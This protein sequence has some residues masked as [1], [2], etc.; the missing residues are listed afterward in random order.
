M[1][2]FL[3][4][5]ALLL[6]ISVFTPNVVWAGA[7]GSDLPVQTAQIHNPNKTTPESAY[8]AVLERRIS[9]AA[10]ELNL[11]DYSG[12][13]EAGEIPIIQAYTEDLASQNPEFLAENDQIAYWANL[14]NA[15]T[16][17]LVLENYPVK[18]IREIKSGLFSTGPWKRDV[19]TVNGKRLSL[20]DI[21]HKILRKRYPN[22]A[23]VHY[24][25]NC[26]SIGCPNL[27]PILWTGATLEA[28]REA[29][30]R[31]FINSPRGVLMTGDELKASSIYKWFKED[32]G[33]S[34]SETID[35]FRQFAG[36]DLLD[37]MNAGAK[38]EK[39][40]YNWD[41]NE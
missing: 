2:R 27:Q 28:D 1:R 41:L 3:L 35:H 37:A 14:Y 31:D 20:D 38:I 24:M 15:L 11:F 39:Y 29:A 25:L 12:A 21:E 16:L 7:D 17:K 36:P 18:S 6:G 30:A 10:A 34:K 32:F 4:I 9:R 23:M 8:V 13:L 40:D 33:G 19:V 26:A 22:P 5:S